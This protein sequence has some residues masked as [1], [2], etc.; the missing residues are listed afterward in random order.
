MGFV[1]RDQGLLALA[2]EV[3]TGTVGGTVTEMLAWV[4][5]LPAETFT[6]TFPMPLAVNSPELLIVPPPMTCQLKLGC[7]AI[8]LPNWSSA[9]AVNCRVVRLASDIMPGVTPRLVNV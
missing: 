4:F 1:S 7:E 5:K 6:W 8:A 3:T 2:G 9:A